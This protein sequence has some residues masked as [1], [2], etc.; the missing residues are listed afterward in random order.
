[1]RE[2]GQIRWD[3]IIALIVA[4]KEGR[5]QLVHGD[6]TLAPGITVTMGGYHTPGSQYVTVDT[7]SGPAIIAG[8]SVSMYENNRRHRPIASTVDRDEN[9]A[10]IQDMHRKAASPFL[11]LPGHDP[12]VMKWFPRVS[13]GIVQI[14][15]Q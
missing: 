12:L 9:L 14:R 2:R 1:M 15:Y 6:K 13:K 5:L 10:T 3:D 11:I 8:D 4:E 7:L